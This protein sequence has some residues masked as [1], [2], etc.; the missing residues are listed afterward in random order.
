MP[1]RDIVSITAASVK[2]IQ[3]VVTCLCG[4]IVGDTGAFVCRFAFERAL[5][6][7]GIMYG[8][9]GFSGSDGF[10]L[11]FVFRGFKSLAVNA[12]DHT[13]QEACYSQYCHAFITKSLKRKSTFTVNF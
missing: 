4:D 9:V 2:P 6:P 8:Y 12:R 10:M 1:P 3:S 11:R 7:C 5:A 13:E